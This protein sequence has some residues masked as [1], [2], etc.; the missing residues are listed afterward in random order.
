MLNIKRYREWLLELKLYINQQAK[1]AQIE[2]I[3]LAVHE[4]H[5]IRK[6]K[7][8]RGIVLCAKY[9]DA[10]STGGEDNHADA[11]DLVLFVLEK[12]SSGQHTDEEELTHYARLQQLVLAL[13][14]R[15]RQDA[16]LCGSAAAAPTDF[17]IEWEYDIYGGWNGLSIGFKL[18][19]YD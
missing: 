8:R 10:Q 2:S 11:N 15:L 5:L 13:V 3:A 9:P 7:D 4:G 1:D 12:V 19:D 17:R 14:D 16:P 6:L 18:E